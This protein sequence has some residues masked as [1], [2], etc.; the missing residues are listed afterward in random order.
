MEG[1]LG[2]PDG[3]ARGGGG[4]AGL[5]G[6]DALIRTHKMKKISIDKDIGQI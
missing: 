4:P 2:A 3:G 6:G 5:L 1:A